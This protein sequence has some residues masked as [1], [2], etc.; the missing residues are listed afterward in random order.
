M[1]RSVAHSVVILSLFLGLALLACRGSS[2]PKGD[3]LDPACRKAEGISPGTRL[4]AATDESAPR[5][6][7][8]LRGPGEIGI[9]GFVHKH[10]VRIID[11][12]TGEVASQT[13][14]TSCKASYIPLPTEAGGYGEYCVLIEPLEPSGYST[15]DLG[16]SSQPHARDAGVDDTASN[17]CGPHG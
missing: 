13:S 5:F 15:F 7:V 3:G 9:A 4:A 2:P 1:R 17:L 16:F 11:L 10:S 8:K 12:G 6:A 14:A